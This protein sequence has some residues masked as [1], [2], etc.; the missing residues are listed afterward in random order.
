M[1]IINITD[2]Q[3]TQLTRALSQI[4]LMTHVSIKELQEYIKAGQMPDTV[5]D[6]LL[7]VYNVASLDDIASSTRITSTSRTRKLKTS[8]IAQIYG[9]II[10]VKENDAGVA[11]V[12][13]L[14][15]QKT[16]VRNIITELKEYTEDLQQLRDDIE[17]KSATATTVEEKANLASQKAST[18]RMINAAV[19]AQ[20]M[21]SVAVTDGYIAQDVMD[22]LFTKPARKAEKGTQLR[23]ALTDF[24]AAPDKSALPTGNQA[25][26]LINELN[27]VSGRGLTPGGGTTPPGGGGGIIPPGGGGGIIPPGGGTTP[28]PGGGT[29]P[30]P[31]GGTTPPPG[32][33]TTPPPGGGTTPPPGGGTTPPPGSTSP[34]SKGD[35]KY[36]TLRVSR[37]RRFVNWLGKHWLLL[38]TLVAAGGLALACVIPGLAPGAIATATAIARGGLY[39]IV[40]LGSII[41]GAN[42][43]KHFFFRRHRQAATD[44]GHLLRREAKVQK[45]FKTIDKNRA[46]IAELELA[47]DSYMTNPRKYK[48]Q[49]KKARKA[50]K[51]LDASNAKKIKFVSSELEGN[52][53]TKNPF[54]IVGRAAKV[55]AGKGTMKYY[56]GRHDKHMDI[57]ASKSKRSKYTDER[58][59][60]NLQD[61]IFHWQILRRKLIEETKTRQARSATRETEA[62][63]KGARTLESWF[64]KDGQ[65]MGEVVD[66]IKEV[67]PESVRYGEVAKDIVLSGADVTFEAPGKREKE[68]IIT[69]ATGGID[70]TTVSYDGHSSVVTKYFRSRKQDRAD[71]TLV[72]GDAVTAADAER[73]NPPI[74]PGSDRTL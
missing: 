52:T 38:G 23:E 9:E 68:V 30:P 56:L 19:K 20:G 8:D 1:A 58:F 64:R 27:R 43:F 29:T 5:R 66:D 16:A 54:K 65:R 70:H 18:T 41:V 55:V 44:Q 35:V 33:G 42:V 17:A 11:K 60:G 15:P 36:K 71:Q 74:K 69:N 51:K 73:R 47:L 13:L 6:T 61:E 72:D 22:W 46:K 62:H 12:A 25:H 40:T 59:D 67:D 31:G 50:L 24:H 34:L 7:R 21:L 45:A 39:N 4:S 28:P 2:T 10:K 63:T 49:I 32:G 48:R 14:G 26:K 37:G 57:L 53:P 3:K